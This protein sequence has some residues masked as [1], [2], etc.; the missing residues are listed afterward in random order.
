M[1]FIWASSRENLSS[2]L[3]TELDSTQSA[4]LQRLA[5]I[6]KFRLLHVYASVTFALRRVYDAGMMSKSPFPCGL[7]RE[8][9][10]SSYGFTGIVAS[11]VLFNSTQWQIRKNRKPVAGRH[12][13]VTSYDPRTGTA[14]WSWGQ[15]RVLDCYLGPKKIIDSCDSHKEPARSPHNA[16]EGPIKSDGH[17][18]VTP[19][20][21]HDDHVVAL[22]RFNNFQTYH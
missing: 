3:P 13:A 4:Q 19:R 1:I 21:W 16:F 18:A 2:G 11:R 9:L 15:R 22:W 17:P 10:R 5:R 7:R 6:L 14:Q 20:R 12:I 8:T